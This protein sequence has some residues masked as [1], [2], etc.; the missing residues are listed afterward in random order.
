[1]VKGNSKSSNKIFILVGF[2]F[3]S[4]ATAA[5]NSTTSWIGNTFGGGNKKWMQDYIEQFSV[6]MDGSVYTN[7]I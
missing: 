1:M 4:Y 5:L 3:L 6:Q 2:L 7:S